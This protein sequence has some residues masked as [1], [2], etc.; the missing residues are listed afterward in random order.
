L[1]IADFGL[2]N[3]ERVV[4]PIIQIAGIRDLDEAIMLCE[5]GATHLGF[6]L[7][8]DYHREDLPE[9]SVRELIRRLPGVRKVLI[10]YLADPVAILDLARFIGAD[11]VQ[12]HGRITSE[13]LSGL[14]VLAP[15]LTIIRSII[16]AGSD[17]APLMEAARSVAQFVD[18]FLT[19]TLDPDTGASGA[20]GKTHDWVVSRALAREAGQPLI[21]AGGLNPA[22]V[23]RAILEVA[24]AGVDSHTGVERPDGRKDRALVERFVREARNGFQELEARSQQK[25]ANVPTQ[26]TQETQKKR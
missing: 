5:A 23:R 22:N 25:G 26:E 16:V 21:L 4:N 8:L 24:P 17:P 2:R 19:D 20:T 7:R 1:R 13:Q 18:F 10:T 12:L 9:A 6:P 3:K 11:T 14:R 15:Q